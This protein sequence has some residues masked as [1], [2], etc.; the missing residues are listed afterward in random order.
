MKL[1]ALNK[2]AWIS[3][4]AALSVHAAVF[5]AYT[6]QADI[7]D[8]ANPFALI[9]VGF[10]VMGLISTFLFLKKGGMLNKKNWSAP[11]V[12]S[13]A[14]YFILLALLLY[15]F[16]SPE[17]ALNYFME[18]VLC[19]PF[20]LFGVAVAIMLYVGNNPLGPYQSILM[21]PFISVAV[22]G[23]IIYVGIQFAYSIN[24]AS[25]NMV[26]AGWGT[27]R[28]QPSTISY[29]ESGIFEASYINLDTAS[30]TVNTIK[31]DETLSPEPHCKLSPINKLF[32]APEET[33][34]LVAI[35]PAK[36]AGR[37]YDLQIRITYSLKEDLLTDLNESGHIKGQV[38]AA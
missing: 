15:A 27:L 30:I 37:Q 31:I 20:S 38:Q 28:P 10:F 19:M 18:A 21:R 34:T 7:F 23:V 32:I 17:L 35:C 29:L 22:V 8:R 36:K 9:I 25:Y 14:V 24:Y 4:L 11:L 13:L 2:P 1:R 12:S 33:F 26:T 3:A 6:V 5:M 16:V